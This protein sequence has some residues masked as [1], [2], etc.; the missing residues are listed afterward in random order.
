MFNLQLGFQNKNKNKK[1]WYDTSTL[2]FNGLNMF[3]LWKRRPLPW[4]LP[5]RQNL[6]DSARGTRDQSCYQKRKRGKRMWSRKDNV[7]VVFLSC[8][9]SLLCWPG[10]RWT[11]QPWEVR[12][13]T[14]WSPAVLHTYNEIVTADHRV[15][16]NWQGNDVSSQQPQC[17]T[18]RMVD[19]SLFLECWNSLSMREVESVTA[20]LF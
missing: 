11:G 9:N 5:L 12:V 15:A 8:W 2:T 4:Y 6:L 19:A 1:T 10:W 17:G 14:T 20:E 13:N 7:S 16:E 3:Y 18:H